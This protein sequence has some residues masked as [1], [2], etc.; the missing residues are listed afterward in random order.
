[1][2]FGDDLCIGYKIELENGTLQDTEAQGWTL[3]LGHSTIGLI[4]CF[5]MCDTVIVG[6]K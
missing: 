5:L 4:V 1:M 2:K 3:S 6:G